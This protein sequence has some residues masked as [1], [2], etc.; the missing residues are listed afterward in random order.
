M[1]DANRPTSPIDRVV[2]LARLRRV[3]T[4]CTLAAAGALALVAVLAPRWSWIAAVVFCT[5]LVARVVL[6]LRHRRAPGSA[7]RQG[8]AV[9]ARTIVHVML[10]LVL[11]ALTVGLLVAE[12]TDALVAVP[13]A[14]MALAI[15]G[16]PVWLAS[17]GDEEAEAEVEGGTERRIPRGTPRGTPR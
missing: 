7:P 12:S 10:A 17:V 8:M 4:L 13:V 11:C 2:V 3:H 5:L 9:G 1:R 15:F 16:G 14:F 6:H